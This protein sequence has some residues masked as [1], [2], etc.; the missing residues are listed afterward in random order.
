MVFHHIPCLVTKEQNDNLIKPIAEE[1][2]N[3][4]LQE[5]PN[6]KAPCP[7][8]FTTEFFKACW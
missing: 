7:D 2:I 4:A 8:G 6:G 1:E 5:M 3:Q